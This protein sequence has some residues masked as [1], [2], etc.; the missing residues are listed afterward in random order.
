M[1]PAPGKKRAVGEQFLSCLVIF[2]N[3]PLKK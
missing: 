1:H 3:Y 2:Y